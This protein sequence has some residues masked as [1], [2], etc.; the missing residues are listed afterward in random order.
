MG[1]RRPP[2]RPH[3]TS[4]GNGRTTDH[5]TRRS[6][7]GF[8]HSSP[9]T[10]NPIL[11]VIALHI[12]CPGLCAGLHGIA[13]PGGCGEQPGGDA[14]GGDRRLRRRRRLGPG[15]RRAV[16]GRRRPRRSSGPPSPAARDA[17][18]SGGGVEAPR[19]AAADRAPAARPRT[20]RA[21]AGADA[22]ALRGMQSHA[23][24]LMSR[25]VHM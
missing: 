23:Q 5:F 20:K 25:F 24:A 15:V 13:M 18:E 10:P 11:R 8:A 2:L 14:A 4:D 22:C 1:R 21:R 6:C 3:F 12:R 19:P 16:R 17:T 9:S 7:R